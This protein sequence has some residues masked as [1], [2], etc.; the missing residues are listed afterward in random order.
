MYYGAA[1]YPEQKTEE[2]L[3][4]DLELIIQSGVRDEFRDGRI[5]MVQV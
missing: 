3:K 2:E 4:H 1:Y 5:C